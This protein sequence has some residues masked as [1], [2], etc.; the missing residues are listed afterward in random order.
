ML[1][2]ILSVFVI[3]AFHCLV[4][5]YLVSLT[6]L[7][8]LLVRLSFLFT[9]AAHWVILEGKLAISCGDLF[10]RGCVVDAQSVVVSGLVVVHFQSG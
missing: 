3:D 1:E 5:Q 10:T 9:W 6:N 2:T 7:N 4:I 8:E